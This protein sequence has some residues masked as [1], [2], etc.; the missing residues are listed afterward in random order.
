MLY[1]WVEIS[2]AADFGSGS[3]FR[4]CVFSRRECVRFYKA[5]MFHSPIISDLIVAR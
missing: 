2:G 4:F 5:R 1:P 3:R